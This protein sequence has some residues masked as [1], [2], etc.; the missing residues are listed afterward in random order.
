MAKKARFELNSAELEKSFATGK[1]PG[2]LLQALFLYLYL[3]KP[4]PEWVRIGFIRAHD[5]GYRAKI[6]SWDK[7]FGRPRTPG[8]WKRWLHHLSIY[9]DVWELV[10]EA[11]SRGVAIDDLLFEEIGERFGIGKTLVKELYAEACEVYGR[12]P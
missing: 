11:K 10:A 8:Q 12:R 1:D 2:A 3:K 9:P 7:V 5:K 4:I 6:S